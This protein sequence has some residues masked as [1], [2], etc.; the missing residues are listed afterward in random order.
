MIFSI[1]VTLLFIAFNAYFVLA[2]FSLI[3]VR[4]S[5]IEELVDSGSRSARLVQMAQESIN[6]YLAAIQ[7]G[8]TMSSLAIGWLGEP[9]FLHLI[10]KFA[11]GLHVNPESHLAHAVSAVF[12]FGIITAIHIVIGE[13]TP[14]LFAIHQ[15]EKISLA[16]IRPLEIFRRISFA[17]IWVLDHVSS[18]I[19]KFFGLSEE[20]AGEPLHS[21][22][23]IRI[24]LDRREEAGK[25]S[26]DSLM[27]FENL[28]D[29][30]KSSVKEVMTPADKLVCLFADDETGSSQLLQSRKY[31]RYPLCHTRAE[32]L[33]GAGRYVHAKEFFQAL[34]ME[35]SVNLQKIS[36]PLA[37]VSETMLLEDC[38]GLFQQKRICMA[39][40][41]NVQKQ[42]VGLVSMEDLVEEIV[43]EIRDEFDEVPALKLSEI[44]VGGAVKIGLKHALSKYDVIRE[45]VGAIHF[46]NP[47]FNLDEAETAVGVRE[48]TLST[49]IG[50]G[51]AIP[52]ARL[53]GLTK[54]LIAF[55]SL[56]ETMDWGAADGNPVGIVFC[57]LTPS[58]MPSAQITILSN[59]AR[60]LSTESLKERLIDAANE[61]DVL[62]VLLAAE[63][64]VPD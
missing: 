17:P 62:E 14:K 49:A 63:E 22:E 39:L 11:P 26:L 9:A 10:L 60:M 50:Q 42:I 13:Q 24:L 51:T 43:G 34:A 44:L 58:S 52:H 18:G 45:L 54:P 46:V 1:L 41:E 36:R 30:V 47:V 7:L 5:R 19:A 33:A 16:I 48:K 20:A 35:E 55:A 37:R 32:G 28:F 40:V 21:D 59:L 61:A 12:A 57:I 4:A 29:F 56:A 8:I 64:K 23:E 2:E 3:R 27:M 25:L 53:P 31:T 38:L 15:A 6:A